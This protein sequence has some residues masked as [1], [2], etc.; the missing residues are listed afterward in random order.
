MRNLGGPPGGFGHFPSIDLT[1]PLYFP[2]PGPGPFPAF[3]L[4]YPATVN[5]RQLFQQDI[6]GG[7]KWKEI[8][9]KKKKGH[10]QS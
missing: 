1:A 6:G 3:F 10:G 4:C 5:P 8:R 9:K 7:A 2:C